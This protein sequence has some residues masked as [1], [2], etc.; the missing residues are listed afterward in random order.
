MNG[1]LTCLATDE[2]AAGA[3]GENK[4]NHRK[5]AKKRK[6]QRSIGKRKDMNIET[7]EKSVVHITSSCQNAKRHKAEHSQEATNYISKDHV[8]D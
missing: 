7:S 2:Y 4:V 3:I 5:K 8:S 6:L 1:L